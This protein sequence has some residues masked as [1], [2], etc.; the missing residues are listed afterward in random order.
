MRLKAN[1]VNGGGFAAPELEHTVS[2]SSHTIRKFLRRRNS[3]VLDRTLVYTLRLYQILF[4]RKVPAGFRA[5]ASSAFSI[6]PLGRE[7][8][9]PQ[10]NVAIPFV[11]KDLEVLPY[12]V[13]S[14]YEC[15]RNPVR[16]ISLVTPAEPNGVKPLFSKKAS[17]ETLNKLLADHAEIELLFDHQ[18][19]GDKVWLQVLESKPGGWVIQQ[20]VK[21]AVVLRDMSTPTLIVDADTVLLSPKT[22]IRRGNVQLLQV[23]YEFEPRYFDVM[24]SF[25]SIRKRFGLSF[26]THHTLMQPNIVAEMFPNREESIFNWWLDSKNFPGAFLAENESYGSYLYEKYPQLVRL[27]SWSNLLSPKF[28]E[29]HKVASANKT[30]SY[31]DLVPHYCSISFHAHAQSHS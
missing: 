26:V 7:I 28:S 21:F 22:W 31:G 19:L 18:V 14:V 16:K 10:I 24:E 8:D 29:F 15:V 3:R 27:G 11:E 12:V 17:E 1:A 25:F 20:F 23:A 9:P 5:V 2:K 13:K 6:N 4:R 30:T